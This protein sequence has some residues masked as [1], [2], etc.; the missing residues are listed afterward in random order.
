MKDEKENLNCCCGKDGAAKSERESDSAP[1]HCNCGDSGSSAETCC[2]GHKENAHSCHCAENSGN[3]AGHCCCKGPRKSCGC[4]QSEG[5]IKYHGLKLWVSA[6]SIAASFIAG[7]YADSIPYY[8]LTDPAWI[9]VILC[10]IPIFRAAGE[11]LFRD[12]KITSALLVSIAMIGA[13]ALQ[14]AE[15]SGLEHGAG[16]AHESYIFVVAEIAFLMSLGEWLEDRTVK[17]SRSGIES[18]A[19]LL[20]KTAIVKDG[21]SEIEIPASE[22]KKGQTICVKAGYVFPA[23]AKIIGGKSSV[24]E[25]SITGES[26]PVEKSAGDTVYAG[27]TNITGYLE[28]VALK[29]ADDSEMSKLAKL[30]EE[31]AGQKAPISRA[32]D[33]WAAA[34]IPAAIA[35]AIAVFFAAHFA[36]GI[37]WIES[38]IRGVTILVVFCPCAFVLAT[39]TAIAAGLGNAAKRGILVKSGTALETL[40]GITKVFF[41]KTG[42]LT[43]AKMRV[44]I[45]ETAEGFDRKEI[46]ALAAGAE[47]RSEHPIGKAVFNFT[48]GIAEPISPSS[49]ASVAGVGIEAEFGNKKVSL[50][51]PSADSP[52]AKKLKLSGFTAVVMKIDG[53]EAAV[54]GVSDTIRPTAK[55]AVERLEKMGLEC[56]II[57]GDN[58]PAAEK[59]AKA[60]SIK[61]VYAP[62]L[63]AQKLE[64]I[65]KARQSGEKV[66]MIGDG[67]NDAPALASADSSMA[68]ASLKNDLAIESA[69]ISIAGT[70]L[71]AIPYAVNLS[72]ASLMT[73]KTNIVFSVALNLASVVLAFFGVINPV[74]GALIHNMSSVCVVLN[75]ARLLKWRDRIGG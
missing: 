15:L 42:T 16:H 64:I 39:P 32:A 10:S 28:V 47:M 21:D 8:P 22:I 33:R 51:K 41:D 19:K 66:C 43:E 60:A 61:K 44:E 12:G 1:E 70:D 74:A 72:K 7:F 69:Q 71:T 58:R 46:A 3:S 56:A 5:G 54:F 29:N 14:I 75:S 52:I 36:L 49:T 4:C 57:S 23:D 59:I 37:P 68:V 27:T 35:T 20:P 67:V 24:D 63:P 50:E 48:K 31:A 26:V 38:V 18:L 9:A 13:F 40:A 2:C 11:S 25:S 53:K 55:A 73:I 62:V 17:K 6:A 45:F 30:V 34:V 65:S